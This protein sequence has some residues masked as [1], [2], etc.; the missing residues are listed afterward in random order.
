LALPVAASIATF[1]VTGRIELEST[2]VI[3]KLFIYTS[4]ALTDPVVTTLMST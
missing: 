1:E 2:A 4:M 3:L